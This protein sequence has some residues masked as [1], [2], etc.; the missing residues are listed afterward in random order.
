MLALKLG[1]SITSSSQAL[2]NVYSLDLDGVDQNVTA[3]SVAGD[4]DPNLGTYSL[5]LKIPT[6]SANAT[7]MLSRADTSNQIAMYYST[8]NAAVTFSLK[9]GGVSNFI[10]TGVDIAGDN[11]WH[12]VAVTWDKAANQ[13]KM[14]QDGVLKSS[15]PITNTFSGTLSLFDIGGN[16]AGANY[17]EGNFSQ[18]AVFTRVVPIGELF[19]ADQQPVDLTGS[20]DLVGYFELNEGAGTVANDSSGS[21]NTG[22]ITNLTSTSWSTDVPYKGN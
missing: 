4:M 15:L 14:Y 19:I 11:K 2:S 10:T 1:N 13:L 18:A 8:Y 22:L 9:G 12:H 3:D 7:F 20:A 6:Y 5:W 17:P 21:G 16:T